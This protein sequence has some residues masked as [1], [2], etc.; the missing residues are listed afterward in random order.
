M[1]KQSSDNF[2]P[3]NR[4]RTSV[5]ENKA[6]KKKKKVT[7]KMS[8]GGINSDLN[9]DEQ[10]ASPLIDTVVAASQV[11]TDR[12]SAADTPAPIFVVHQS[13][14]SNELQSQETQ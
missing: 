13:Q 3:L 7:K 11:Q 4:S 2:V 14:R 5:N 9:V 6:S 8:T 12:V 1:T 10:I